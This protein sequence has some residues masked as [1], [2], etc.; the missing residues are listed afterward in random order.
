MTTA[1]V[2]DEIS[3]TICS[4]KQVLV[5]RESFSQLST[6]LEK[7]IPI[8]KEI[9]KNHSGHE[10]FI[11]AVQILRQQVKLAKALAEYCCGGCSKIY[12]LISCRRILKPQLEAIASEIVRALSLL[13][14]KEG[15]TKEIEGLSRTMLLFEFQPTA[16]EEEVLNQIDF[17]IQERNFNRSFANSLLALIAEAVG[18]SKDPLVL[19]RELDEFKNEVANARKSKEQDFAEAIQMDHIVALLEKA[20]ATMSLK[21]KE[22]N[23]SGRRNALGTRALEPLQSFYC[24]ITGEVMEDPVEI[25]SGQTFERRAIDKWIADGNTTCPLTMTPLSNTIRRPNI[26]LRKSIEEWK[27]RNTIIRIASIKL[28]LGSDSE[29]EMVKS[30]RQLQELCE[31]KEL[32]REYVVLE[33]CLKILVG[34][35]GRSNRLI[36]HHTLAILTILAKDGDSIKVTH[37]FF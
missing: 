30:L 21:D 34:L 4:A 28:I 27:E 7:T 18:I 35:L 20:D 31:E 23:Y 36:R 15:A 9:T 33:N 22:F 19:K 1:L 17:G 2:I 29:E 6:C 24:P 13:C 26:T 3:E 32:Y 25:S 37:S 10:N 8:L 16:A 12:L 5:G 14:F 11:A